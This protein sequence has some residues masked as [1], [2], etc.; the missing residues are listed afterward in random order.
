[1]PGKRHEE[2]VVITMTFDLIRW[3]CPHTLETCVPTTLAG[4]NAVAPPWQHLTSTRDDGVEG[5]TPT[6]SC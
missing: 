4:A 2:L 1:M 3:S 6:E 5:K